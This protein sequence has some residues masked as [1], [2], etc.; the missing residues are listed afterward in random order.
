MLGSILCPNSSGSGSSSSGGLLSDLST[1]SA[2]S[3]GAASTQA[4]Q[5]GPSAPTL[6]LSI[7]RSLPP[8]PGHRHPTHRREG[9]VGVLAALGH[10]G[11]DLVGWL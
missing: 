8:I 9:S 3:V 11:H 5:P 1:S 4:V 2:P 7:A 6:N 10:L